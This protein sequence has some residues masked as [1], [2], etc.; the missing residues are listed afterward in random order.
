MSTKNLGFDLY[1][2]EIDLPFT[3]LTNEALP[4]LDID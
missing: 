4:C 1:N 2:F 3:Q